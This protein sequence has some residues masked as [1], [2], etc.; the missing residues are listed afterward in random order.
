MS[1]SEQESKQLELDVLVN[2]FPGTSDH[3]QVAEEGLHVQVPHLTAEAKVA[4]SNAPQQVDQ[5]PLQSV[6]RTRLQ[7]GTIQQTADNGHE[8]NN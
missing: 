8:L 3:S 1:P 5:V 2:V 7:V 6:L 4:Q